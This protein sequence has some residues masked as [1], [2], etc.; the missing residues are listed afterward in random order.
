MTVLILL[1]A[2]ALIAIVGTVRLVAIDGYRQA[3]T[4][5]ALGGPL[6]DAPRMPH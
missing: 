1:L 3:P 4:R 5:R 6:D 2:L